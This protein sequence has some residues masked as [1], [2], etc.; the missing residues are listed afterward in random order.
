MR[1]AS[2]VLGPE[3]CKLEFSDGGGTSLELTDRP[4]QVEQTS[5]GRDVDSDNRPML[6]TNRPVT[7]DSGLALDAPEHCLDVEGCLDRSLRLPKTSSVLV[8]RYTR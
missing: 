4:D 7:G 2:C 5:E 8:R 3:G 1:F 6:G